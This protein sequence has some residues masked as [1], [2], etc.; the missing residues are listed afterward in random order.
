MPQQSFLGFFLGS[1]H[2]TLF[3]SRCWPSE[4]EKPGLS[5]SS[6]FALSG[7]VVRI[8][9]FHARF[10]IS[11]MTSLSLYR[12]HTHS[13]INMRN[14]SNTDLYFLFQ[15]I[16]SWLELFVKT[17]WWLTAG[18]AITC[19]MGLDSL[20]LNYGI[21]EYF[22]NSRLRTSVFTHLFWKNNTLCGQEDSKDA[23]ASLSIC[24]V[25]GHSG[26]RIF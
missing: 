1:V 17:G 2:V 3:A 6:R 15:T 11:L 5:A 23:P 19:Q 13:N 25:R 21:Q 14:R 20:H 16:Q 22:P 8:Y 4:S 12:Y 26:W 7:Q 24:V 9:A 18:F 10:C